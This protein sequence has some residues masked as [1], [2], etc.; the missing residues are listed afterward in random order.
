MNSVRGHEVFEHTA[1]LGI[2][3][4][5]ATLSGLFEEMALG[6][7]A[8]IV[9]ELDLVQMTQ[10]KVIELGGDRLEYLLHDWL[11][12]ILYLFD[13]QSLLASRF[14]VETDGT[15]LRAVCRGEVVDRGRHR[16]SHEVKA[17]TYHGLKVERGRRGWLA[18]AILDI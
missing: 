8:V 3:G 6:L 11:S 1:D 15:G 13:C 7:T 17:V 12:E 9:E 10:S 16:L 5:A 2:R 4:W 14:E 18:E